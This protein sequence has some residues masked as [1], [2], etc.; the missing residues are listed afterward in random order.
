MVNRSLVNPRQQP[1]RY[2]RSRCRLGS[3]PHSQSGPTSTWEMERLDSHY[4]HWELAIGRKITRRAL[5]S[6]GIAIWPIKLSLIL[7]TCTCP[8]EK[9]GFVSPPVSSN[10]FIRQSWTISLM[11]HPYVSDVPL[12]FSPWY[13]MTPYMGIVR[14]GWIIELN[15]AEAAFWPVPSLLKPIIICTCQEIGHLK[16][17]LQIFDW[18]FVC[19]FVEVE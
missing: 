19:F 4:C 10:H 8:K 7:L 11:A 14:N 18:L 1:C 16:L 5:P 9:I 17:V 13:Q 3:I 2:P 15:K 6:Q 12:L